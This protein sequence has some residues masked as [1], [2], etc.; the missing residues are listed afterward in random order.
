MPDEITKLCFRLI[1][2]ED[3]DELR[4]AATELKEAIRQRFET[5]RENA[6]EIALLDRLVTCHLP[7]SLHS[8][9]SE[10]NNRN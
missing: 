7:H 6:L 10:E 3:P 9:Q 5:V 8:S 4:P 2:A 1:R